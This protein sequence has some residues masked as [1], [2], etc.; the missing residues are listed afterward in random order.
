MFP[1]YLTLYI[2]IAKCLCFRQALSTILAEIV[3]KKWEEEKEE[4]VNNIIKF[5]RYMYTI[6]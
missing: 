2:K 3:M 6:Y 1:S 5:V 4:G